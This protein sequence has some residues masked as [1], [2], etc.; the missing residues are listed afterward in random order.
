MVIRCH[1]PEN[2]PFLFEGGL[3]YAPHVHGVLRCRWKV[4]E[5]FIFRGGA[6]TMTIPAKAGIQKMSQRRIMPAKAGIH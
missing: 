2:G 3:Q 1:F 6:A 5:V 4:A